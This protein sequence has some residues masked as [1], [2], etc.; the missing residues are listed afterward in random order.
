VRESSLS[1]LNKSPAPSS[2]PPSLRTLNPRK[3]PNSDASRIATERVL[4]AID[5]ALAVYG[6]GVAQVIY[7]QLETRYGIRKE[8]IPQRPDDFVEMLDGFFGR[9]AGMVKETILRELEKSS[10]TAEISKVQ[11]SVA[12]RQVFHYW[13]REQ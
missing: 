11:L 6:S 2:S 7:F 4:N 1:S 12:L 13:L 5:S 9:G 10:G 8:Q 3:Y